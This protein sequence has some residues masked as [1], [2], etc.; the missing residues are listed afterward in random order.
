MQRGFL[1]TTSSSIV[2][3]E[4]LNIGKQ[5]SDEIVNELNWIQFLTEPKNE[6]YYNKTEWVKFSNMSKK[7]ALKEFK[8]VSR[9]SLY[10]KINKT[11]WEMHQLSNISCRADV[12]ENTEDEIQFKGLLFNSL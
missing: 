9:R 5:R 6:T 11:L 3:I 8:P 12:S 2:I 4:S 1:L 7:S 10:N